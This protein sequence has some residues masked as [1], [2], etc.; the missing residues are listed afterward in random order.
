M[1]IKAK[2]SH[3]D[4]KKM[5]NIRVQRME[6]AI[7]NRLI[8]A[9]EEFVRNARENGA[10][11]DK[12]GNLR[13][14]IGYVV[15]RNGIPISKNI[16]MAGNGSDKQGGVT[17]AQKFI[18]EIIGKYGS[19]YALIGFAG[20]E[21]AAKVESYGKDVITSSATIA[22]RFLKQA[23]KNIDQKILSSK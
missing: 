8:Q 1:P 23:L 17:K 21:Y 15:L 13:S 9:G 20:M 14:S 12:T 11:N 3:S 5:F 2:F 7:Q 19:G 6:Q 22:E 16:Q 4:I 10:Y 18:N